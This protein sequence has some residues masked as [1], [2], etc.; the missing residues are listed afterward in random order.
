MHTVADICCWI[1]RFGASVF[2]LASVVPERKHCGVCLDGRIG[3][4]RLGCLE[5]D[6]TFHGAI[7]NNC[8]EALHPGHSEVP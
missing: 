5:K 7:C 1:R 4:C 2:G 8:K 3:F 6:K